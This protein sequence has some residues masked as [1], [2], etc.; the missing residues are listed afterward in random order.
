MS[1]LVQ[2]KGGE[3][4]LYQYVNQAWMDAYKRSSDNLAFDIFTSGYV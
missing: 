1:G 2:F 3:N 4:K